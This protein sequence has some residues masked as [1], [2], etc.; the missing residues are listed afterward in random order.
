MQRTLPRPGSSAAPRVCTGA[1][2]ARRAGAPCWVQHFTAE[3]ALEGL[4]PFQHQDL[5][6]ALGE[7]QS[8]HQTRRS[9][10]DDACLTCT[11]SWL[12]SIFS[13]DGFVSHAHDWGKQWANRVCRRNRSE[14][15]GNERPFP[16]SLRNRMSLT[17]AVA[18]CAHCVRGRARSVSPPEVQ[19]SPSI[20]KRRDRWDRR[21]CHGDRPGTISEPL[22]VGGKALLPISLFL[23]YARRI[24]TLSLV[25]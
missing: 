24:Y 15:E 10:T 1:V 14:I 6:A 25:W 11:W 22:R 21:A 13:L 9:S 18:R 8:E 20:S 5:R 19:R 3:L 7:Q 16:I 17:R 12:S 23:L 2:R 4:V